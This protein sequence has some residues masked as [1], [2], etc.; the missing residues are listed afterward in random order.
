MENIKEFTALLESD[1]RWKYF[2][3]NDPET[4]NPK[5]YTLGDRYSEI[6]M[7]KLNGNVPEDV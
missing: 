4:D 3:L 7:I 2:A 5:P 6:E 1:E